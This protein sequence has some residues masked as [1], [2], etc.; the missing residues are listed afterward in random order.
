MRKSVFEVCDQV[1]LKHVL[2]VSITETRVSICHFN[3]QKIDMMIIMHFSQ[4]ICRDLFNGNVYAKCYQSKPKGS[5]DRARF[6]F[7]FSEFKPRQNLDQS[8]MTFDNLLGYILSISMCM[9]NF[10]TIF[11]SV[12]EIGPSPLFQNLELGKA[13]TDDKCHFAISWARSCRYQCVCKR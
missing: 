5:R 13:S 8:Q 7:I 1:R 4:S 12:Q 3:I 9:Q 6:T 2:N 11:Y 10:I